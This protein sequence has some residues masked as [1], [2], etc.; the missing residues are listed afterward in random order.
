MT[1]AAADQARTSIPWLG[2]I[3][4]RKRSSRQHHVLQVQI[5]LSAPLMIK[6][7]AECKA[8]STALTAALVFD[9]G[10]KLPLRGRFP[11]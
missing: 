6:E 5:G 2:S 8:G 1:S 10:A 9:H 4:R 7:I 11:D 3:E